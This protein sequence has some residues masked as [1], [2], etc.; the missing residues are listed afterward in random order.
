[1]AS[2]HQA[3]IQSSCYDEQTSLI[4]CSTYTLHKFPYPDPPYS[5]L[6]A[7]L[8]CSTVFPNISTIVKLMWNI[9]SKQ[10]PLGCFSVRASGLF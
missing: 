9:V 3:K 6:E 7:E 4:L 5:N 10:G 2:A 1:M 8:K